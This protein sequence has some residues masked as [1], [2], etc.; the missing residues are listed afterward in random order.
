MMLVQQRIVV[1]VWIDR[2]GSERPVKGDLIST[3]SIG[4]VVVV[5]AL[6][7]P[8]SSW[9][10]VICLVVHEG[11]LIEDIGLTRIV[12]NYEPNLRLPAAR[13]CR[14]VGDVQAAGPVAS[15]RQAER[16]RPRAFD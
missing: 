6:L 10:V 2:G 16:L 9:E 3:L 5:K 13:Q 8:V 4:A 11:A 7:L 12:A 15:H 1:L 14:E